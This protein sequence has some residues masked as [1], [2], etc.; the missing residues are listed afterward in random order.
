MAWIG[1]L[2]ATGE[3]LM[4]TYIIR[5]VLLAVLT[6]WLVSVVSFVIIQLPPGDFV[7]SY[8]MKLEQMGTTIRTEEAEALRMRYGLDQPVSMQYFK[9]MGMLLRGEFGMSLEANRAVVDVIGDRLWWTVLVSIFS[10]LLTWSVALPIGIYSAVKQYSLGD[11]IATVFGFV[12]VSIPNFL[13]AIVVMYA[14]WAWLGMDIG[15]LFSIEYAGAPWSAAKVWDLI[16]HLP[17]PII[18]LGLSGTAQMIRIMRANLLDELRKPYVLTARAKGMSATRLIL[19]YPV[20]VAL[21]PF[22][23]TAGYLLPYIV[24]GSVI[25]S[26]VMSLPM[27]GPILLNSLMNQ[28]MFLAGSIVLLLS[29]LTVIGTLLSDLLLMVIDPRIRMEGR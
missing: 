17:L 29:V 26:L 7:D 6:M 25:V 16:K 10:L 20:R 3:N 19:R 4:A 24:S 22:A 5:R 9:W 8:I 15:G 27:V 1:E 2:I 23:S 18:I 14:G 12:G 28:D 13:L 11:Y 21:N